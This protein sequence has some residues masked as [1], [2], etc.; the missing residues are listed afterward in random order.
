MPPVRHIADMSPPLQ[1]AGRF[2][3]GLDGVTQVAALP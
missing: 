3:T 2:V 1:L